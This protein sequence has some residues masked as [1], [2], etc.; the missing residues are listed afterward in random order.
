MLEM[1]SHQQARWNLVSPGRHQ[2]PDQH[3]EPSYPSLKPQR[4]SLRYNDRNTMHATCNIVLQTLQMVRLLAVVVCWIAIAWS[5]CISVLL[6]WALLSF[7]AATS[8]GSLRKAPTERRVVPP[9]GVPFAVVMRLRC[10]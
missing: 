8:H 4:L 2:A 7:I 3:I 9:P 10:A 1:G 5:R 6:R